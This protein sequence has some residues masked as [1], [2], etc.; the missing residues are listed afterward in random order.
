VKADEI[1]RFYSKMQTASLWN[2][3][4]LR[5]K[6]RN[7]RRRGVAG[8]PKPC[9]EKQLG[10]EVL[11]FVFFLLGKGVKPKNYSL[12]TPDAAVYGMG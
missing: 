6:R 4:R 8:R 11:F 9:S 12:V 2:F 7:T 5:E 10:Y 3:R 1:A